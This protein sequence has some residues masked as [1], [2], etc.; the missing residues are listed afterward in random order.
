MIVWIMF[1]RGTCEFKYIKAE[2]PC[3]KG[4]LNIPLKYYH[5][6]IGWQIKKEREK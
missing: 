3:N 6:I 5:I 2:Y 1:C 4:E